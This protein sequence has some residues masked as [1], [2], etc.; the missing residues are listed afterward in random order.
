MVQRVS[1][2]RVSVAGETVGAIERGLLVLV[3]VMRDDGTEDARWLERKVLGLRVFGD[4]Q[5]RMNL[6]VSEVGGQIL[7]ISQFTL[8]ADTGRGNRPSFGPA[9]APELALSL[10]EGLVKSMGQTVRVATGRFGAE[11]AVELINEGPVTLWLDSAVA[12]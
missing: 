3:G 2:A 11:M 1:R 7:L 4:E 5:G 9:M 6:S 12:R 8:C 10:F